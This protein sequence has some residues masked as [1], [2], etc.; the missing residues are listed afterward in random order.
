[1]EII[2]DEMKHFLRVDGDED[3]DLISESILAAKEYLSASGVAETESYLYK[4]AVKVKVR[5]DYEQ[6]NDFDKTLQDLILKLR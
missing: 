5:A 4:L 2:L 3:N 6:S 1:M